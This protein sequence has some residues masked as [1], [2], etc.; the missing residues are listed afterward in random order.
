MRALTSKYWR[1]SSL[2]SVPIAPSE[3]TYAYVPHDAILSLMTDLGLQDTPFSWDEPFL[4]QG[5]QVPDGIDMSTIGFV[6]MSHPEFGLYIVTTL[7]NFSLSIVPFGLF[8]YW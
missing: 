3:T 1:I 4:R 6:G 2:V 7:L 8:V 5:D